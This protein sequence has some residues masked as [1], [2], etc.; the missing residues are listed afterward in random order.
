MVAVTKALV[1]GL[2]LELSIIGLALAQSIIGLTLEQSSSLG[3]AQYSPLPESRVILRY[4]ES[5]LVL[6]P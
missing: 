2:V 3:F 6:D 5:A 4:Y 1:L